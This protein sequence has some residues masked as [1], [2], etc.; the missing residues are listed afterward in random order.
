MKEL[1]AVSLPTINFY[2]G[3]LPGQPVWPHGS[4][5][6]RFAARKNQRVHEG[7]VGTIGVGAGRGAGTGLARSSALQRPIVALGRRDRLCRRRQ[8]DMLVVSVGGPR[9][10]RDDFEEMFTILEG[11][12]R[13]D[14]SG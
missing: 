4:P 9:P 11:E 5:V 6:A 8:S 10:H 13:V 7:R 1:V 12:N 2:P 14:L 3:D